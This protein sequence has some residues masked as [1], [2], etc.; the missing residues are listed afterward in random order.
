MKKFSFAAI[1]VLAPA[2]FGQWTSDTSVNLVLAD[3]TADQ[4]LPKVVP[5]PDGGSYVSWFDNSGP[6]YDVYLQRLD[7]FGVEQFA[8]NGVL[9]RDRGVSSTQDY[10]LDVDAA[11]N[12]L[13]AYN[14]DNASLGGTQQVTVT[15]VS[16]A[17]VVIWN[18][19][20]TSGTGSRSF[21]K[22]AILNDGSIIVGYSVS[23]TNVIQKLDSNGVPQ[24]T[25]PGIVWTEATRSNT[26]SDIQPTTDGAFVVLWV[27]GR[28]T[29]FN[30]SLF[31]QKFNA[32]GV[33]QWTGTAAAVVNAGNPVIIFD[34]GTSNG[35]G[36][37]YFPV[38]LP[39]NAGGAVYGWYE[40]GGV[41]DA[42]IQRVSSDGA[43]SWPVPQSAGTLP[44]ARMRIG[45]GLSYDPIA[46]DVF[47]ACVEV[48]KSPQTDYS[49]FVQRWDS[50]G[51]RVWGAGTI[52]IPQGSANQPSFVQ[53]VAPGGGKAMVFGF[54]SRTITTGV[55]FG[56]GVNADG[57]IA[58]SG[59][60]GSLVETKSRLSS[61]WNAGGGFAEI[62]FGGAA[63]GSTDIKAQNIFG[64][65]S[66][67][68]PCPA[69]FDGS[70][71][72]PDAGDVDAFFT[73]W[74]LGTASADVNCSGGTPDA[75]DVDFFFEKWLNGG[76]G[77]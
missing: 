60:P 10:D 61:A 40:G 6:G 74:L 44:A 5:L 16:P 65:G 30:K 56:A 43:L 29:S 2:A 71:G 70:G 31:T 45:A 58:W 42:Y 46:G 4:V 57:T 12:A 27:R 52:I 1:L 59:F 76:C 49:T 26:I 55:V 75:G 21:P 32:A 47:L 41:R 67:G 63:S 34:A 72:T 51:A 53:S 62:A 22:V 68:C 20:V 17:G 37:G 64:D 28:T 48:N 50:D 69:D 39:D 38:C 35:L 54:D 66:F 33:P 9:I 3:R 11:G 73:Q 13:L 7:R 8:H 19:T 23:N 15:K 18:T 14:D 77:A 24:F 25:A 36:N